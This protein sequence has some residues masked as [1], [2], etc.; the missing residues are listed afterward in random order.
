MASRLVWTPGGDMPR[1]MHSVEIAAPVEQV[2]ALIH[3]L[4]ARVK[5]GVLEQVKDVQK[6][7]DGTPSSYRWT[8]RAG[9]TRVEGRTVY[10]SFE[11][12]FQFQ[13]RTEAAGVQGILTGTLEVLK[14]G[15]RVTFSVELDP[16]GG[17]AQRA[18]FPLVRAEIDRMVAN[19]LQRL[20]A[21]LER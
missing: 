13:E 5:N 9:P 10:L 21:S 11:P 1:I 3:D 12:P 17:I 6:H 18:M 20:K 4:N 15:A 7:P 2:W 16:A 8:I 19:N 14:G